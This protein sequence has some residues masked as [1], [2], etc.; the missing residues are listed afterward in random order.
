[1]KDVTNHARTGSRRPTPARLMRVFNEIP[2]LLLRS[3]FHGVLSGRILLLEVT[4]RTSGRRY[5]IPV[6][7]V[8]HE[9]MLLVGAGAPWTKNVRTGVP[10]AVVLR[11]KRR[12]AMPEM[13]RDPRELAQLVEVILPVNPTWGR[14]NRLELGDDGRVD[15]DLFEQAYRR[16][17]TIIR[18]QLEEEI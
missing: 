12:R 3:P 6:A 16:G 13:V 1:M 8:E 5:A 14:F 18:L 7:Y 9:G 2:K 10:L 17:L 4:G 15:P 11:G